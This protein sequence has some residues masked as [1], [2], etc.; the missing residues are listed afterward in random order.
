ME[1]KK[2]S[3]I[4]IIIVFLYLI[5][6][7]WFS[8]SILNKKKSTK[9]GKPKTVSIVV[10]AR[11]EEQN[12]GRLYNFLVSQ[13]YPI[14]LTEIIIVDDCSS[15]N[16]F[17]ILNK[18][19]QNNK[20]KVIRIKKTPIGWSSKKWALTQAIESAT[21][22]IIMQTDA[23]CILGP[24]WVS[25]IMKEFNNSSIIFISSP[26]LLKHIKS[27]L[28]NKLFYLDS[29]AQ[30]AFSAGALLNNIVLSSVG[31]NIAFYRQ[32]FLDID[33]YQKLED[34]ESGDDDLFMHK[35]L[36]LKSGE[37]TFLLDNKAIVWSEAPLNF[38][39]FVKQRLRYASK[40]IL[41]YKIPYINNYF[42]IIIPFLFLVNLII[43]IS[44]VRFGET[45]SPALIVPLLIKFFADL[46][47][48][49]T[50]TKKLKLKL[51][52]NQVVLLSLIHPF[53]IIIFGFLGPLIKV[54]WKKE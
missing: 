49:Y 38:L 14:E 26:S 48:L 44:L 34:I 39:E 45:G 22:E 37:A 20:I 4:I 5:L 42:K 23:D 35:I 31:R 13:S 40:G 29:L 19:A 54:E 47:L 18:L 7:L 30:D 12:I 46:I 2:I 51:D 8:E 21:G 41:Y 36:N 32:H 33:G 17:K 52:I 25:S 43:A 15:D 11:N 28:L 3:A 9:K 10:S 50:I 24:D 27:K 16:S 1:R 53:Y 6:L